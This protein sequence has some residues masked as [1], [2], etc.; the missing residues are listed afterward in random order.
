MEPPL[1]KQKTSNSRPTL[2]SRYDCTLPKGDKWPD[3]IS[4]HKYLQE[5]CKKYVFQE[6]VGDK[7]YAHWQCRVSL[8][9]PRRFNE[10]KGKFCVGAHFAPTSNACT[11]FQYCMKAD[12]RVAG[13][14]D[15]RDY[16][17]PPPL[18]RQLRNFLNFTRRPWQ[19]QCELMCHE[20]DD[21]SIKLIYDT[22]GDSG[23]SIFAEYLE[24]NNLAY[25]IPPYR[26]ME[27]IL[28]VAM[29]QKPK[30]CY[31]IDMPRG[32]KKE[33]LS[34]FYSGL[35]SLKNG[36]AYDKRYSFRK[37][38]FDRPQIIVYTNHLPVWSLMSAGRWEVW[39]M[40]SDFSLE[41]YQK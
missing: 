31:L 27:D 7:G 26:S 4:V 20:T 13:P 8:I 14:W 35:E 11:T 30:K 34:E 3:F 6:E 16:E 36:V 38:R 19:T 17:E 9:K 5:W 37:V 41:K 23:K 29:S 15:D 25:E 18:T 2:I 12:S 22:V 28:A 39:E 21:R 24:Y 10:L 40:Q 1:K 33:K 32:M